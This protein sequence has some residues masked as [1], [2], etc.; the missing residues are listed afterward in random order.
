[1]TRL[2]PPP[3]VLIALHPTSHVPLAQPF[4]QESEQVGELPE[5]EPPL[6]P[7]PELPPDPELLPE[8][9]LPEPEPLS[10][11]PELLPVALPLPEPL[12]DPAPLPESASELP[13]SPLAPWRVLPQSSASAAASIAHAAAFLT[14]SR[15]THHRIA[16]RKKQ[17]TRS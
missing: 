16:Q 17:A 11:D 8:M 10:A 12:A 15:L 1:M 4:E 9:A 7:E 13:A 3:Q 14:T 6:E 2:P 5:P